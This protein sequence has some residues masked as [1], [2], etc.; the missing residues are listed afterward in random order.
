MAEGGK[1][2]GVWVHVLSLGSNWAP[3]WRVRVEVLA[4]GSTWPPEPRVS[5]EFMRY[6]KR[7]EAAPKSKDM[8][9]GRLFVFKSV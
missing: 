7:K 2:D 4:L 3:E 9:L 8:T 5:A 1:R 6:S